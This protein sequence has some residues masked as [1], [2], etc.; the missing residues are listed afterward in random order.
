VFQTPQPK[1]FDLAASWRGRTD[2]EKLISK[3]FR[4][5]LGKSGISQI[6]DQMLNGLILQLRSVPIGLRVD[7]WLAGRYP[8][9]QGQQRA[10]IS[11]QL[12][13]NMAALGP[14][15]KCMTPT[16]I[17]E[18]N[19][20]MNAAFACFWSRMWEDSLFLQPYKTTGHGDLG[21]QLLKLWDEVPSDPSHDRE[22]IENWG[23]RLGL[24]PWFEFVQFQG[25]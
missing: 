18:A 19:A 20:G 21:E 3:Q 2:A 11:G 16:K 12:S 4:Q 23:E 7:S 25:S 22:L 24:S 10:M 15:V 14:E 9:L 1:R 6:R 17:F 5:S 13:E 8:E